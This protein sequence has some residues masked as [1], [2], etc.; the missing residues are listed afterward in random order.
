MLENAAYGLINLWS[1]KIDGPR[2]GF[3]VSSR[4]YC[5]RFLGCNG[6]PTHP[7]YFNF[8]TPNYC[9]WFCFFVL[10]PY[11]ILVTCPCTSNY[12]L[13]LLRRTKYN[14][15]EHPNLFSLLSYYVLHLPICFSYY[16]LFNP[17][18]AK[19]KKMKGCLLWL[20][21]EETLSRSDCCWLSSI[22]RIYGQSKKLP[23]ELLWIKCTVIINLELPGWNQQYCF[24]KSSIF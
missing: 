10:Y 4:F 6:N 11:P 18:P 23:S 12:S 5:I 9:A 8:Y 17:Y 2:Q 24:F 16:Q 3:V 19:W 7:Q 1:R 13:I 15:L 14:W 22:R 20:V 21:W